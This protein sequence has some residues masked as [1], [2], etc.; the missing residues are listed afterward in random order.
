MFSVVSDIDSVM[1]STI[2]RVD[3]KIR[4]KTRMPGS[5]I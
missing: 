4:K 2:C 5:A 3:E 1:N